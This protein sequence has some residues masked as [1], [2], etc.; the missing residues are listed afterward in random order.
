MKQKQFLQ[1][2]EVNHKLCIRTAAIKFLHNE[3]SEVTKFAANNKLFSNLNKKAYRKQLQ[4]R[5]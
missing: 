3:S 1:W 2:M 5:K 4:K